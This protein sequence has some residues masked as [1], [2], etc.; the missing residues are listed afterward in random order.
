M[1]RI[2]TLEQSSTKLIVKMPYAHVNFVVYTIQYVYIHV[3]HILVHTGEES[4]KYCA[5]S[6]I[7]GVYLI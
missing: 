2:I 3:G 4:S 1:C 6:N 5:L 7:C